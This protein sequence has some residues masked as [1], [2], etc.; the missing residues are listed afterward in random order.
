MS[1][2]DF[3]INQLREKLSIIDIVGRK[4]RWDEKKTNYGKGIYWA[5]CNATYSFPL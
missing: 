4:V 3:F 2:S 1:K 5:C